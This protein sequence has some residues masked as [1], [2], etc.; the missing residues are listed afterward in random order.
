MQKI[1]TQTAKAFF[2]EFLSHK[3][4]PVQSELTEI[5]IVSPVYQAEMLINE[6][7]SRL[8]DVL[9]K[10]ERSYEIILVD[11][12]STDQSWQKIAELAQTNQ[13]VKAIRLS[14][15]F[16]Q[17]Q[18]IFA[19]LE[20]AVGN[21]VV[22]MDC[23]LQDRPEGISMLYKTA[24]EQNCEVV[25]AKRKNRKDTWLKQMWSMLFFK[26]LSYLT[27]MKLDNSIANFGIYHRNVIEALKYYKKSKLVFPLMVRLVG[28]RQF[29]IEIEH[30][31]TRDRKSTYSFRKQLNLAIDIVLSFS[32]KPLRLAMKLGLSI[33]LIAFLF[34]LYNLYKYF[35]GIILVPGYAS[36]II[37]IWFLSGI[38]I[39]LIG[40]I[41]L[42]VGQTFEKSKGAPTY[43]K[44]ETINI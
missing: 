38:I 19:G 44:Q 27:N 35:N 17:H 11:D 39:F 9:Q 10:L 15:N 33:S 14:K 16:G 22:V 34:G 40:L 23:D 43:I 32:D 21:W 8:S 1:N 42:Y 20:Q 3:L 18:A 36:I 31:E 37:S 5:S 41:G 29:A 26:V 24:K 30:G 4:V 6:L 25:F 7:V 2:I 28:F 12:G 13:H